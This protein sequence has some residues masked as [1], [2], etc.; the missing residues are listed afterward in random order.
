MPRTIQPPSVIVNS[1]TINSLVV[2]KDASGIIKLDVVYQLIK[3][4]GSV[5]AR[6]TLTPT[7]TGTQTTQLTNIFNAVQTAVNSA[8]GV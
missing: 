4:D 1:A 5:Y 6:N 3:D 2:Y 7:L 8:E